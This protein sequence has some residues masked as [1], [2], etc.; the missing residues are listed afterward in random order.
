MSATRTDSVHPPSLQ[1]PSLNTEKHIKYWL[2]C[3]KSPLPHHYISNDSN[4]MCFAFFIYSALDILNVLDASVTPTERAEHVNWVYRCQLP[5]GGFRMF[6]G[7]DF[8]KLRNE[9]NRK[10]DPPTLPATFFAIQTLA[11]MKDD[12]HRLNRRGILE[13]LPKLQRE[14]GSFGQMLV[15]GVIEGGHDS[16]FG[17]MAAGVRW[18]LRGTV[19]GPLDGI[20]DI[21]MEGFCHCVEES[22]TYDGGISEAP[23]H[24]A[25]GMQDSAALST[26]ID[27]D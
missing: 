25:H 6:P 1:T 13:W 8:G 11:V 21:D 20:P 24:E 26:S 5:E 27:D 19:E 10:W 23:F 4:R 16:R 7:S 22:Q 15:D 3:L 9:Q 17:Y 2:R 18:M 12:F 14:D